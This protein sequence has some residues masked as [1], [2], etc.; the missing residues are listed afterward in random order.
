MPS[1][2]IQN[3]SQNVLSSLINTAAAK[4]SM[5]ARLCAGIMK[6]NSVLINKA[7]NQDRSYLRG[8]SSCSLHAEIA[9]ISSS[10]LETITRSIYFEASADSIDQAMSGFPAK[11]RIFF[12]GRRLLPP[13]AGIIAKILLLSIIF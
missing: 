13:L 10:S 12:L 11:L 9:A 7:V 2:R 1:S 3:F 6:N 4:G 8:I 5:Q